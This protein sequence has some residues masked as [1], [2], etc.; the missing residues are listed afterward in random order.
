MSVAPEI[1]PG[2]AAAAALSGLKVLDFTQSLAGP[3]CTQI[4]ADFGAEVVKVEPVGHGDST[5]AVGPFHASDAERRHSGYFHSINR[6]KKSLA[7][8][9][10]A[11]A[12]REIVFDLIE[13]YDIVVENFR[14]GTMERL[15]L[16][17]EELSARNPRLIYAAIRGFGDPR[18]GGSPYLDW[19]SFDVVAQAMG[20]INAVT[21]DPSQPTKIGPGVGDIVPG[22]FLA[23][24]VLAAVISR[25]TTG[26]GQ[27]VDVAMVD[28]I[29]ALSERIVYQ[30]SFGNVVARATGNHQPFM[31]PFGLYPARD[32][33][34]AIA[35]ATQ[36]F[37][38]AMCRALDADDLLED[39]RFSSLE[40]RGVALK[41]VIEGLSRHT[42]RFTKAELMERLG[43]LVPF[44]PVYTMADI[45]ADPH[46]KSREMLPQINLPG[47]SDPLSIAG[48]PIKMSGTPGAIRMPGPELGSDTDA[49]LG[50]AGRTAEEIATLRAQ[51]VIK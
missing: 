27:F 36:P 44:G 45:A 18:S 7:I 38:N 12:A 28:A 48:I 37:F 39:E 23:I 51:G 35:A 2:D 16:S 33:Y 49:V 9:L 13:Q 10:K 14:A 30:H 42:A 5:R 6:N 21:G 19:P 24:G 25:Q 31:A 46:F 50:E 11:P 26:R 17:F 22:M 1:M 29:L 3:Y 40:G 32:G 43:G 15:G 4:L 20:G 41:D 34:V 47:V 8:D